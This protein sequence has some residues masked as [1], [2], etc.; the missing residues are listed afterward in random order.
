MENFNIIAEQEHSTVMAHYEVKEK[1]DGGYQSEAKLENEFI[2]QLVGLGYEY[3]K[4]K[5]ENGLLKNLRAQLELLNEVKLSDSEWARLLPMISNEQMTIQD[6][7]EMLQGKG[8][9]LNLTMDSGLTKNIKL[10]DKTNV[11]NNRLQVINQYEVPN[12][13]HKNRYDVTVLVN[14]LP[15]VHVEL[16]RRGVD[17]KEAFNQINRY[18]RDSFWASR[19]DIRLC[20]GVRH[21]KRHRDQIL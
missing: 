16:K 5:D 4:V 6:K 9:I 8:Y 20:T 14:G 13:V 3:L 21:I 1:P 15:L 19:A 7:T 18:Q 2:K 17:I 11:H 12:G 10:W